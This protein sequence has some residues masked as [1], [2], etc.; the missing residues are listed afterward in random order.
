MLNG[1]SRKKLIT[2]LSM[3]ISPLQGG[4][5]KA[6]TGQRLHKDPGT[7]SLFPSSKTR[8][9]ENI[10]KKQLSKCRNEVILYTTVI[11][12]LSK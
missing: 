3:W 1:Y 4:Y 2:Q 10:R 11:E 9:R 7:E 5:H 6:Q 8:H 12:K